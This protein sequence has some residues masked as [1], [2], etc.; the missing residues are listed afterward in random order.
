MNTVEVGAF[1]T[2]TTGRFRPVRNF[3]QGEKLRWQSG[4]VTLAWKRGIDAIVFAGMADTLSTWLAASI[5]RLRGKRVV[6]WTHGFRNDS[7]SLKEWVRE[8]FYRL[9]HCLVH[10]GFASREIAIRRGFL[11]SGQYV[12][13][14][15][16]DHESHRAIRKQCT[17]EI[18]AE[19][20]KDLTGSVHTPIL[21]WVGRLT[22]A[23][24]LHMLLQATSS[25]LDRGKRVFTVLVGDGPE[26]EGLRR[27][28]DALGIADRVRF[29]GA[30]YDEEQLAR[31]LAASDICVGP[32]EIGL[33]CIHATTFGTPII[34]H[35]NPAQQ[36]PEQEAIIP[37]RTGTFFRQ[38]DVEDLVQK[39]TGWLE[40]ATDRD[41]IRRDCYA[42][43]DR[44]FNPE[45]Q[46][47]AF[48]DAV[49]E[50]EQSLADGKIVLD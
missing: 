9:A 36:G 45:F 3:Y 17:P 32:G 27:Q 41:A 13:L 18:V 37:G 38:G 10:Y 26:R 20:R 5:A 47:R 43:V 42:V 22:R 19:T 39:I 35:D 40:C 46:T 11:K 15:S 23:K 14:N 34:T 21:I 7:R 16:L 25:L 44:Y 33:A 4:I 6:F 12:C 50:R 28:A 8:R 2:E 49:L 30:C 48:T 24:K 29:T 1:S 31:L